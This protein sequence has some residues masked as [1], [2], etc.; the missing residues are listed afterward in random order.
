[1]TSVLL[2]GR[3]ASRLLRP[4]HP[5][6][7]PFSLLLAGATACPAVA[8][9]VGHWPMDESGGALVPDVV[10]PN[11]GVIAGNAV[12]VPGLVGNA[13]SFSM[14]TND[15][16]DLGN[17]FEFAGSTDFSVSLWMKPAMASS[18]TLLPVSKHTV[19][20]LNGWIIFVN[21]SGGCYGD[22]NLT[23]FY[24]SNSCGG[25]ITAG[26]SV[27]DGNWHFVVAVVDAGTTRSLYIDGGLAQA[28]GPTN[29]ITATASQLVFGGATF[30]G[31]T[32][33]AYTGLLDDVQIYDSALTCAQVAA[34]FATPGS[35]APNVFDINRDGVV[36]GADLGLL[37][38]EWGPC[39][40]ACL[41]DFDCD[42]DVDG[43]DLGQLLGAWT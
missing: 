26:T 1:M 40:A 13:L 4:F 43:A 5:C 15:R 19:G 16:V 6:T 23:S 34:M 11:D 27:T 37:L 24:T 41:A 36:N 33:G 10:G 25:E 17:I 42:G 8:D 29:P 21:A 14:A 2:Q 38:G 35:T 39:G 32:G 18:P 3:R 20:F 22:P 12:F 31:D 30:G 9:L 7:V 28:T